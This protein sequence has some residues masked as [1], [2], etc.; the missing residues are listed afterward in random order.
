MR[1]GAEH[2][3]RGDR[4][5][6]VNALFLQGPDQFTRLGTTRAVDAKRKWLC[7]ALVTVAIVVG[8]LIVVTI[9]PWRH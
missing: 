4:G 3:D 9:Q 1:F 8:I 5:E 7:A 6:S 2:L